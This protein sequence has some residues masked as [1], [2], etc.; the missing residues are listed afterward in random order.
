MQT[1][2]IDGSRYESPRDLHLAL[3]RMLSLPDYYG[4]NADALNDCLSERVSPVNVWILDPGAGEVASAI[5]ILRTVFA[6]NG[7]EVKEL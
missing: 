3:K 7:G 1:I 6:D 5:S 2:V 4:M